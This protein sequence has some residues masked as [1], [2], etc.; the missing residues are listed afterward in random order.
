MEAPE[1]TRRRP[2]FFD[3]EGVD[4]LLSIVLELAAELWT[5]RERLFVLEALSEARGRPMREAIEE[6]ELSEAQQAEL[7]AMRRR[8][9]ETLFRTLGRDHRPVGRAAS[10][11][12]DPA[13]PFTTPEAEKK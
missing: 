12:R 5:V 1:T 2:A 9:T 11:E 13:A 10:G 8:M 7:A 3:Q 4:Q 6:Y